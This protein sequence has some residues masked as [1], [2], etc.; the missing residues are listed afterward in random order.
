MVFCR[1]CKKKVDDCEHFV[2]PL[3]VP[4][5]PVFDPKIKTLA[6]DTKTQRLEISFKN[7]QVWQLAGVP[8]VMLS[9]A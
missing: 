7:G 3:G 5:I 1:D 4:A 6:Y 9:T 8:L 2:L